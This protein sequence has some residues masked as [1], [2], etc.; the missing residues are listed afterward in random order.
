MLTDR[1]GR[2]AVFSA[3]ML[4]GSLFVAVMYFAHDTFTIV[5][6]R[7]LGFAM[8]GIMSPVVGTIVVE[9]SPPRY[10]GLL[11]GVLQIGYPIG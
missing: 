3:S 2:K 5:V 1:V 4:V 8:G 9:E 7:T 10:R 11:S 6:L